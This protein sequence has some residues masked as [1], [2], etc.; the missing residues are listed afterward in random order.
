MRAGVA[1]RHHHLVLKVARQNNNLWSPWGTI[2]R[3]LPSLWSWYYHN[4][5]LGIPGPSVLFLLS[6]LPWIRR[7]YSVMYLLQIW[8]LWIPPFKPSM[9][10]CLPFR[11]LFSKRWLPLR[12]LL[13]FKG[14]HYHLCL[15]HPQAEPLWAGS[16]P[17]TAVGAALLFSVLGFYPCPEYQ[18]VWY[19]QLLVTTA[20]LHTFPF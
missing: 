4:S 19:S 5:V 20:P 10:T 15:S 2:R 1:T 3:K 8:L 12:S 9:L 7:S 13:V 11:H 18:L 14:L 17:L 6:Q 16:T